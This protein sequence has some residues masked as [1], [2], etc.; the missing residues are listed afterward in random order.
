MHRWSSSR[1]AH[2]TRGGADSLGEGLTTILEVVPHF[3]SPLTTAMN[4][5]V[6]MYL[7][8][9]LIDDGIYSYENMGTNN[10][11]TVTY[12]SRMNFLFMAQARTT[13][14]SALALEDK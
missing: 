2:K 10:R 12:S 14:I 6:Y 4:Y 9:H 3:M 13:K 7:Q 8:G 1:L 5:R 11:F